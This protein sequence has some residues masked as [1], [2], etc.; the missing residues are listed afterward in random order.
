MISKVFTESDLGFRFANKGGMCR[1]R[2]EGEAIYTSWNACL[3]IPRTSQGERIERGN[4]SRSVISSGEIHV[5]LKSPLEREFF[6]SGGTNTEKGETDTFFGCEHRCSPH[7][8]NLTQNACFAQEKEKKKMQMNP[9]EARKSGWQ[10]AKV[11][12]F[13]EIRIYPKG[14]SRFDH[15]SHSHCSRV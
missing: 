6:F 9:S 3:H 13:A 12:A 14:V 2:T 5:S 1:E 8:G 11:N 4:F 15:P 7:V 10:T